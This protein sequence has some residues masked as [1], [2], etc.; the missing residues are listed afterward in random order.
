MELIP[1]KC[2][3]CGAEFLALLKDGKIECP[4]CGKVDYLTTEEDAEPEDIG[5]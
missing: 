1:L 4:K 2:N 3:E 5:Q